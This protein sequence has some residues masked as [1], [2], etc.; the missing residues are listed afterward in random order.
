MLVDPEVLRAFASQV[1]TAAAAISGPN[2]RAVATSSADGV[3]GSA[4]Q[5]AVRQVGHH[6][7]LVTKDI[8]EDITAMGSA[9]RGAGDRYE[10]DDAALA[11]CFER[12]F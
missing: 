4:T 5:W 2:V 7:G 8:A 6:L 11:D 3:A 9:V 10:V 12:L 1:D